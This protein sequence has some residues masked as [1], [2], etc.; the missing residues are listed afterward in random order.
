MMLR[1]KENGKAAT[2]KEK[3]LLAAHHLFYTCGI[4]AT[5][6]DKIIAASQV[7]KVTFYRHFPSKN[8]LII[9]YLDYRHSLWIAWF[10]QTLQ[11]QAGSCSTGAEALAA[12]L[13]CWFTDADFRGCAFINATAESGE[14]LDEIK[15]LTCHHKREMMDIIR[16]Q[17]ALTDTDV[18]ESLALLI[19]GA[20]VHAQMG[21]E[22]GQV[23]ALLRKT[24]SVIMPT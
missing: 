8:S 22:S 13:Q 7:T 18:V 21:R 17:F 11:A 24:A 12:T 23:T 10:S 19:D 20:I 6:I 1:I 2:A 15:E 4:K 14:L 9:S 3:I 16:G 5:G